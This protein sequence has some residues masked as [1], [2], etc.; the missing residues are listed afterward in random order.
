VSTELKTAAGEK[1]IQEFLHSRQKAE[2]TEAAVA[3]A[4]S[5]RHQADEN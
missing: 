2:N 4:A 5:K 3:A 1:V